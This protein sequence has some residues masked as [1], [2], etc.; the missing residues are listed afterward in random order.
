MVHHACMPLR[1]R[2]EPKIQRGISVSRELYDAIHAYAEAHGG[3]WNEAVE[4]VL[5]EAFLHA[6][7]TRRGA[8]AS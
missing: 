4:R 8:A 5:E 2:T 6:Q 3:T 7:D 1:S